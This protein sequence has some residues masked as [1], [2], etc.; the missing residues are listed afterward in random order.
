MLQAFMFGLPVIC[1]VAWVVLLVRG[2]KRGL[3]ISLLMGGVTIAAGYWSIRQSRA[4]TAGIAF[5]FLPSFA[6]LSGALAAVFARLRRDSRPAA[7]AAGWLCLLA[8]VGVAIGFYVGGIQE[9]V[10]NRVRDRQQ[11]ENSR[12]IDENR[13]R[14]AQLLRD[15]EGHEGAALD[16]E[17]ERHRGDRAFLIPALET[18]FVSE[19][20][21]DQL[22]TL[23]DLGV[24]LWVARNPRTRSDTLE[25][26][27]RASSYPPY[28]YQALAE[29]RN[30]PVGILRSLASQPGP[31]DGGMLERALAH[32]PSA[33]RDLLERI[34]GSGDVDALR[35]LLRNPALDCALL[36]KATERLGPDARNQVHSPDAT[37]AELEGRLCGPKVRPFDPARG[38]PHDRQGT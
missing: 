27:Y 25:R 30:T 20:R 21:L 16:A 19:E 29:H 8:S 6:A 9:Q 26:I 12:L 24:V 10:K 5:L 28:F 37:I 18:R 2:S 4:S 32:N 36:R 15:N 34:A 1:V 17:L 35:N 33:P 3:V 11:V 31:I 23:D 7:R 13:L 22:S 38:H 14:I